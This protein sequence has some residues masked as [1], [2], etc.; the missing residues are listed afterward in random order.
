MQVGNSF[1]RLPGGRLR[2]GEG[3]LE[4]LQRKLGNKLAPVAGPTTHWEIN[5]CAGVW[6]RPDFENFF[7][8][9]LPP[10]I[11]KPK[12][13]KKIYLVQLPEKCTFAVPK[14]FKLLAVPLFE[15]YDK[16]ER[17]GP[18]IASIPHLL[19]RFNIL[20]S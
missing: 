2:P 6:W 4:G 17:Y 1:W 14:N 10:H 20:F 12:E 9:Y 15:L 18:S 13:C 8:P 7:Y 5:D 11:T 3:E 19:S 16:K